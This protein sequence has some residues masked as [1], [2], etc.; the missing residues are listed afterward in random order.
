[1]LKKNDGTFLNLEDVTSFTPHAAD[2]RWGGFNYNLSLSALNLNLTPGNYSLHGRAYDKSGADSNKIEADFTIKSDNQNVITLAV[3]PSSV[4]EDG[5]RNLVYTFT[6][7]GSAANAL[8]VNY[9]ITGTAD[10]SDYTGATRGTGKTITFAARSS[11]RTLT[12]DPIAD[13][14]VENNETVILTL[15]AGSGYTVGTTS[16]VT[17]TIRNDD[18]DTTPP[19][20]TSLT[21]TDNATGVAVNADLVVNFDET[22]Q[23]GTGNIF[24]KKVSDNSIVETIAVTN[25]NVTISGNKLTINPTNDLASGTTYYVQI[26]NTAIRDLAGNNYAGFPNSTTTWRFT[27]T[28]NKAPTD[29]SLPDN[30]VKENVTLVGDFGT[31]DPDTGNTFTYS[32]VTGTGSNDNNLFTII[33]NKLKTKAEVG[34]D[35]EEKKSHSI[36][37]RTTDQGG[38]FYEKPFTINVTD[39]NEA[40]TDINLKKTSVLENQKIGTAVGDFGTVDQD[41]GNTF[42]YSLVPVQ[43]SNNHNLFSISGNQLKTNAEFDFEAKNSY[44]I[45]VKTT[46]QGGLSYEKQFTINVTDDVSEPNITLAVSSPSSVQEDDAKNLVY[47]FTSTGSTTSALT[48]NYSITG[49]A[50]YNDNYTQVNDYTQQGAAT[51]T[52]T[53]GTITFA[54]NSNK[55]TLTIVP[56][57]DTTVEN[58]E[59]VILTLA[60]GSGYTV[61]TTSGVTGTITNDDTSVSLKLSSPSIVREN[62]GKS[63]VYE[64]TRTGLMSNELTVFFE[65]ESEL[66]KKDFSLKESNGAKLE[67]AN[68]RGQESILKREQQIKFSPGESTTQLEIIPTPDESSEDIEAISL[69]LIKP[70]KNQYQIETEN[71]VKGMVSDTKFYLV[72]DENNQTELNSSNIHLKDA[73][74]ILFIHGWKSDPDD[75]GLAT[76]ALEY[77]GLYPQTNVLLVD[78]SS[79]AK[80]DSSSSIN[81][82]NNKGWYDTAKSNTIPIGDEVSDFLI[83]LKIDP[84]NIELIGH[85]LGSHVSGIAGWEYFRQTGK[86]L[87][88]IIGLD[89]AGVGYDDTK[90]EDRL[91][92][93]DAVRVVGIHTD[94]KGLGDNSPYG[95]FDVYVKDEKGENLSGWIPGGAHSYAKD[96][97]RGLING[98]NYFPEEQNSRNLFSGMFDR[99]DLYNAKGI[100]N[101]IV[102]SLRK[103]KQDRS[104]NDRLDADQDGDYLDGGE[105]SDYLYGGSVRDYLDGGSGNDWLYGGYGSDYLYGGSGNDTFVFDVNRG[106]YSHSPVGNPDYIYDFTIGQD[107]ILLGRGNYKDMGKLGALGFQNYRPDSFSRAANSAAATLADVV[108]NVFTDANGSSVGNQALRLNSAALVNVT[109]AGIAGTYLVINDGI[110]GFQ[111]NQDLVVN[112]TGYIG[113]L[114]SLGGIDIDNVN[115]FF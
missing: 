83:S 78:W 1:W 70:S 62:G 27:T 11:T 115:S 76:I 113:T 45:R 105:G 64:F 46:D 6:R 88:L 39:V 114:P 59:T 4:Q 82:D 102:S 12:I 13:T 21:P 3:S 10:S 18:I 111:S 107:K 26:A 61:G 51:F 20:A 55:A 53:T 79:A 101:I 67:F 42:T 71:P 33:S 31:V 80:I 98:V 87:G 36:R 104:G 90:Y 43:N 22:I 29:L 37:V 108:N 72:L 92:P 93:L 85:S 69:K 38:L 68:I 56:T 34:L 81:L 44:N 49:T 7:T 40:P 23:K 48:V 24:I 74:T 91:G 109:T 8:T 57:A 50:S 32:L 94:P 97:Y 2:A 25:S 86:Q 16:G 96:I 28:T 15:A 47:T 103:I 73:K 54:A 65:I 112:L 77:K 9:D 30:V 106:A 84:K 35:F 14:T 99:D 60:A 17:G 89:A 95:H 63:L 52:G 19:L 110:A 75:S 41:T 66:Q 5:T 58:N 100:G